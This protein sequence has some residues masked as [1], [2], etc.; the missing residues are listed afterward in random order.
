M[1]PM[2]FPGRR[3]QRQADALD[4]RYQ[5]WGKEDVL[6]WLGRPEA[7]PN[8]LHEIATLKA[9]AAATL[10]VPKGIRIRLAAARIS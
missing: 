6:D 4:R 9:A 1:K 7:R 8:V 2:N 10:G 5:R 3:A